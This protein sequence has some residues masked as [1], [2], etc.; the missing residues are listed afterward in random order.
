MAEITAAMVK[1]L[2]ER[3][4]VGMM[5]CKKALNET[6]GDVEAAV[7]LLRQRGII[8]AENKAGRVATEGVVAAA[9]TNGGKTVALVE[10][11]CE[12]DFVARNEGFLA[13]VN[14][15]TKFVA[16]KVTATEGGAADL[17][18][19]DSW[20]GA[21]VEDAVKEQ[22]AVIGEKVDPRRF[23]RWTSEGTLGH[24]IH[25]G[26]KIGALVEVEGE[27][28]LAGLARDLAVHVAAFQPSYLNRDEVP[29]DEVAKEKAAL[30]GADDLKTKPENVREKMVEGRLGKYFEQV[31]ML[32]QPFVKDQDKKVTE[33]LK[34]AKVNL[35]RFVRFTLGEGLEKKS[36][37]FAAEV[38]AMTGASA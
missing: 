20:T 36:D 17:A 18:Q 24:Y 14:D 21:K 29:A 3:T 5:D 8:K 16:E 25:L 37:D 23:V 26:G 10:I 33:V 6:N 34:N 32:E 2:R 1:E 4:S 38:A 13:F 11:N 7:T 12:T 28:D 19:L 22:I 27:G 35:K 31:V 9:S 15:I 30:M